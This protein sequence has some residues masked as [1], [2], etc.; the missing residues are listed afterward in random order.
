M[1]SMRET[2]AFRWRGKVEKEYILLLFCV[3][4]FLNTWKGKTL[5]QKRMKL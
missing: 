3:V 4:S 1:N 5:M 2:V